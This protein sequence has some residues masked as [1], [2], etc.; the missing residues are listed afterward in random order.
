MYILC[1]HYPSQD[2]EI[3]ITP[4]NSLML[5]YSPPPLILF[6]SNYT[7]IRALESSCAGCILPS[8]RGCCLYQ[9]PCTWDFLGLCHAQSMWLCTA[10]L[11]MAYECAFS[12]KKLKQ[13]RQNKCPLGP[14][15][16]LLKLLLSVVEGS[17][18][19]LGLFIF[20]YTHAHS[21]GNTEIKQFPSASKL[22]T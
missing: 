6:T 9:S 18:V 13:Y 15:P 8:F 7:A 12:Y 11:R 19:L 14:L 4:E 10:A 1:N 17:V 20:I 5:D 16:F 3:Y 2:I 21:I 22:L